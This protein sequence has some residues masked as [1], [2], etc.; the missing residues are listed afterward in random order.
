VHHANG[1]SKNAN[2]ERKVMTVFLTAH[3]LSVLRYFTGDS[4][5]FMKQS[6]MGWGEKMF[7]KE[8]TIVYQND[9]CDKKCPCF[10]F[11]GNGGFCGVFGGLERANFEDSYFRNS[12]CVK[13]AVELG[14]KG[15][16]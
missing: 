1:Y 2:P 14:E 11:D 4:S 15:E 9:C 3:A 10:A 6:L 8:I 13:R 12:K 16:A 5:L 7:L